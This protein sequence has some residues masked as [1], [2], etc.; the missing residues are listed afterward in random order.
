MNDRMTDKRCTGKG[1][2][3]SSSGLIKV[4]SWHLAGGTQRNH[5]TL[6]R[7]L[8]VLAEYV[9]IEMHS[10]TNMLLHMSLLNSLYCML[11]H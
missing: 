2:E 6:F 9:S 3:G 10:Y 11:Y 5:K 7:V 1:L 4:M 8:G